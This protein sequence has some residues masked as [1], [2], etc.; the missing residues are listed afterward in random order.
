RIQSSGR[1]RRPRRQSTWSSI[2]IPCETL[3]ARRVLHA[4]V[5]EDAEHLAVFGQRDAVTG[6]VAEGLVP[7]ASMTYKSIG[8]GNWSAAATWAHLQ[9]DGTFLSDG[10]TPGLGDNVLITTGT[11]VTVD[12]DFTTMPDAQ[13]V[14]QRNALHAIRDDGTLQFATDVNTALLV[15]TI[16]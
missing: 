13:G 15:D 4:N 10:T 8:S 3:E 11:T 7:D 6:I 9:A 16:I 14:P 2:T 12:G 1:S 5:V